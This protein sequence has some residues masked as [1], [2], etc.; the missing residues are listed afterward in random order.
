MRQKQRKYSVSAPGSPDQ[1]VVGPIWPLILIL[2]TLSAYGPLTIDMY[3]PAL[4]IIAK[5]FSTP[6]IQQ[7]LA[8]YF[9]GLSL[10]QLIY[11]PLSDRFGRKRPLLF[12]SALYILASVGC[13]FSNSLGSL[14]LFRI[15]Q[16][17]GSSVG[18]VLT[19][20]I[21]RDLFEPERSARIFSYLMLVMGFAPMLAPLLGGQILLVA[22]WRIIFLV[23]AAFGLLC[24][25]LVLFGLRE[26]LLTERRRRVNI[27]NVF[28]TYTGILM[29]RR[30]LAYAL[31]SSLMSA[32]FFTY[33]SASSLVFIDV[34]SVSPQNFGWI[35][36]L[37]AIGLVTVAQVNAR[38]LDWFRS[39][40]ILKAALIGVVIA[41]V[42]LLG[43]VLAGLATMQ[44]TWLL[45][46]FCIA[47]TG[48]I[49]PN[50]TAGAMAN[51]A[52]RAGST[53]A[54]LGAL[55]SVTGTLAGML[56]SYLH[57]TSVLP[58]AAMIASSFI[59]ALV[60]LQLFKTTSNQASTD[61][62]EV[63]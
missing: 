13:A 24:F 5:E 33:L 34:F 38:L 46:F 17:L 22:S 59:L 47:G 30:F 15:L 3:L 12:G 14:I 4:P 26:S 62:K 11:G 7:T 23:L 40:A 16:A 8:L 37:N 43:I 27:Q 50:T 58:M 21:V 9:L 49:R 52:D 41:S 19:V 63:R 56:L 61:L 39:D 31:P 48:F 28:V 55:G 57:S 2:G 54:L 6:Y 51:F 20:S 45:L 32:G 60:S 35:F 36:G 44:V 1:A 10:G 25:L 42:S 18:M 53:S 29:D